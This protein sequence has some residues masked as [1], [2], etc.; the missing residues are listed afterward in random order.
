MIKYK[1]AYISKMKGLESITN[2]G[3]IL[4]MPIVSYRSDSLIVK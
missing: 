1:Q 2:Y 3:E 4:Q